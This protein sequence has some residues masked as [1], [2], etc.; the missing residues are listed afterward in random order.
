MDAKIETMHV[1]ALFNEARANPETAAVIRDAIIKRVG[2]AEDRLALVAKCFRPHHVSRGEYS[3]IDE[4]TKKQVVR[5]DLHIEHTS[6]DFR[7]VSDL[8]LL[9]YAIEHVNDAKAGS[10]ERLNLERGPCYGITRETR[11]YTTGKLSQVALFVASTFA[12][13]IVVH[14]HMGS[15]FDFG[16]I[17][18]EILII[19]D[20]VQTLYLPTN[21]REL[22]VDSKE[23]IL[24]NFRECDQLMAFY[25]YPSPSNIELAATS[26]IQYGRFI[27]MVEHCEEND[28]SEDKFKPIK[29]TNRNLKSL[30]VEAPTSFDTTDVELE[31]LE[32]LDVEDSKI[33]KVEHLCASSVFRDSFKIYT[34]EKPE[35][36]TRHSFVEYTVTAPEII[37][38]Q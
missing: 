29:V 34:T 5:T 14:A 17:R 36:V 10:F 16:H 21:V 3:T 25:G 2:P 20:D 9:L 6:F 24:P 23:V 37:V 35:I 22:H 8:D 4:M 27:A 13:D 18:V 32:L 30:A 15:E 12:D 11:Q 1:D 33:G 7:D 31:Y 19:H 26:R 28:L 38:Q